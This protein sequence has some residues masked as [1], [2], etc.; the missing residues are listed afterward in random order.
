ME[1][2]TAEPTTSYDA[3]AHEMDIPYE[4]QSSFES[5]AIRDDS[6]WSDVRRDNETPDPFVVTSH[7]EL[8]QLPSWMPMESS[9]LEENVSDD[10][11][12]FVIDDNE[13]HS[14]HDLRLQR[15]F[16]KAL[17]ALEMHICG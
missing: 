12:L 16:T 13:N 6:S 8:T 3:S 14:I 7:T 11:Y 9:I 10:Y 5:D 4:N 1:P 2:H 17:E 15:G